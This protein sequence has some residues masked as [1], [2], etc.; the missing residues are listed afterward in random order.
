MKE[1]T[2]DELMRYDRHIKLRE[3]GEKGQR[4]LCEA[5]VLV[6]GAG[7]LGSP[8]LMYLAAAGVG[9]L[10]IVDGD[11]VD[12]S[13]LQRQIV[14]DSANVGVAKVDSA[15]QRIAQ[16]NPLVKVEKHPIF[17]TPDNIRQ[18][19]DAYDFVIEATDNFKVKYMVNDA[20]V[21]AGKPF[22]L[23]G[24]LRFEGQV[25]TYVPGKGPCYRCIF[26]KIP[27]KESL[28]SNKEIGVFGP[29][30]GVI[31]NIQALE[32][33]KYLLNLGKLLT[34]RML[35][36]EALDMNV[37]VM[38]LPPCNQNCAVCSKRATI[39]DPHQSF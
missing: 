20:C 24:I 34:G 3:F 25:M 2:D 31:G 23:G 7:G 1:F 36:I 26:E 39:K 21:A 27:T 19:I 32:C 22:C 13:N 38:K 29:L 18:V 15:E 12:V 37:K 17:L 14:H 5:R 9:T 10:G 11:E 4:T 28:P 16:I 8:I 30:P 6:I 35:T 33:V